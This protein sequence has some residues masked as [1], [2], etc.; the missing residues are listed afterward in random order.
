MHKHNTMTRS[1]F[2]GLLVAGGLGTACADVEDHHHDHDHNHG[3]ITTVNLTFTAVGEDGSEGMTFT[4]SDPESDGDP[5]IDD[6]VLSDASDEDSHETQEYLVDIELWNDLEEPVENVTAEIATAN[7]EHQ[8]F[9][10]GS[11]V[12][13]PATGENTEAIVE[14]G[15]A[16][17]DSMGFPVGLENTISTIALGEGQLVLTLRHLPPENDEAV[18]TAD[19]AAEV[20]SG[21]FGSIGGD[22]DIQI[23]FDMTVE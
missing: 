16:D 5:E 20:A 3:L 2:W 9:F 7:D 10:T 12:S 22:T 6:I 15:Y 11:A 18:K 13:G 23:E 17:S 21:G 1:G 19:L 14:H 4:W 8:F